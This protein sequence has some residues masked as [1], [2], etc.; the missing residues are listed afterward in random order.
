[1]NYALINLQKIQAIVNTLAQYAD[2]VDSL[3]TNIKLMTQGPP[4][5]DMF[6]S[7]EHDVEGMEVTFREAEKLA[8]TIREEIDEQRWRI[9]K[10]KEKKEK[11]RNKNQA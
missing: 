11:D 2:T 8:R 4:S 6:A 1:M 9:K 3:E 10:I 7:A 5:E